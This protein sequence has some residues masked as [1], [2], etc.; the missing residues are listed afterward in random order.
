MFGLLY[1]RLTKDEAFSMNSKL[2][3]EYEIL[4]FNGQVKDGKEL[5]KEVIRKCRKYLCTDQFLESKLNESTLT[6]YRL[7]HC[8]AYNCL[9]SLFMR[10]QTEIKLYYACLFKDDVAKVFITI[11][12]LRPGLVCAYLEGSPRNIPSCVLKHLLF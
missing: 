7:L 9:V 2:A 6:N 11:I 3:R 4:K 12:I 1:K 8:S 5:T 10:T